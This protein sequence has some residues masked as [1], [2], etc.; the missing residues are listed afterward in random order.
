[1]KNIEIPLQREKPR[2]YR[3]FEM[4]PAILTYS[5]IATPILLSIF[6]PVAAAY[7]VI[8]YM[9]TWLFKAVA[10]AFRVVQGYNR[11]KRYQ[12]YNW[13]RLLDDVASP[14][15]AREAAEHYQNN[16]PMAWH[17]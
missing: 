14:E 1:M 15:N 9:M 17:Y 12:R 16:K 5:V 13:Q 10:M 8:G 3:L 4:L 6:Y 11:M 7:F 2:R